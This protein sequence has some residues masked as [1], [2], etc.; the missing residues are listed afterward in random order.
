VAVT[1]D[2][3]LGALQLTPEPVGSDAEQQVGQLQLV[4]LAEQVERAAHRVR[5][6]GERW[7]AHR[8][9]LGLPGRRGQ[10]R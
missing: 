6:N 10:Q 9:G 3:L 2:G 1:T 5:M 8:A 4:D 7:R